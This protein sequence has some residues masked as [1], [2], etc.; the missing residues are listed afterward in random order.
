MENVNLKNAPLSDENNVLGVV[1]LVI[2]YN[3]A[4]DLCYDV[5]KI[6]QNRSN[7]EMFIEE[8]K[9]KCKDDISF[10]YKHFYFGI[11]EMNVC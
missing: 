2:K 10:Q 11:E 9:A 7:A 6:F 4:E 3:N 1:Y 8:M 5:V